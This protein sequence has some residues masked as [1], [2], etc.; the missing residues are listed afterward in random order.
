MTRF[1]FRPRQ[2]ERRH[3]LSSLPLK[4]G[5]G[6]PVGSS[7]TALLEVRCCEWHRA[8]CGRN[9]PGPRR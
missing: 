4:I 1:L 7:K 8:A 9:A 5:V 2:A 3:F 6:G